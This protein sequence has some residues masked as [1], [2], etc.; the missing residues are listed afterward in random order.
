MLSPICWMRVLLGEGGNT[1]LRGKRYMDGRDGSIHG[2]LACEYATAAKA[3]MPHKHHRS[4]SGAEPSN[5]K[6]QASHPVC[7]ASYS[8]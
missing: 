3:I 5:E 2:S 6:Q 8:A 1:C 4:R 7:H